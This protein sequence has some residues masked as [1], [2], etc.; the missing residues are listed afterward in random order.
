MENRLSDLALYRKYRSHDFDAVIGQPHVVDTLQSAIKSGRISHAYLFTGPR[1]VGKT[2]V[3]RLLARSLN[4]TGETKP[5]GKCNNCKVEIS[6][7]LD[8]IEIDAASNRRID[9][10]RD[11]R[12][13]IG[14]APA[15]GRYKV[16]II[17]E[18]HMLTNE[19]FNALLKTLEEPPAHA[20]F[21]LVTT[22]AHKLPETIISRTQRFNFKP[23]GEAQLKQGLQHVATE[24][25]IQ[26]EPAALD[27]LAVAAR[28]S[29]R[30][31]I[32]MLDQVSAAGK[33][34]TATVRR[35]LG[36]ADNEIIDALSLAIAKQQTAEALSQ[37]D[38]AV[39]GGS[40]IAQVVQQLTEHWRQL[41]LA[42][43]GVAALSDVSDIADL[44]EAS[45][46]SNVIDR[47]ILTAQSPAPRLSLETTLVSLTHTPQ[48]TVRP[49]QSVKPATEEP[50]PQPK[51]QPTVVAIETP[52]ST[53]DNVKAGPGQESERWLKALSDVKAR[54]NSLY[55]L[56]RSCKTDFSDD[57]LVLSCRFGFH[58]D[59]IQEPKNRQ[60]IEDALERAFGKSYKVLCQIEPPVAQAE[61]NP[62]SEL[63]SSA[64]KILGGEIVDG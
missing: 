51:P 2:T 47:L 25:K 11:L 19:A 31:G 32:S 53:S 43:V 62:A 20:V 13:K 17:D 35:I 4:C 29:L 50:T 26:L 8:L 3:A 58:R 27:L 36:W 39:A 54:N 28:G 24:E 49:V 1:G 40:D 15:M 16:Y 64:L 57:E 12:D 21:I 60:I 59:R 45:F 30:D 7:H 34:D 14:L 38:Q 42:K 48:Q 37:L 44:V 6:G 10:I 52:T 5:C 61:I 18:V 56:L 63:V 9:E 22:E 23:L 33:V 41:L 46:I 55:A